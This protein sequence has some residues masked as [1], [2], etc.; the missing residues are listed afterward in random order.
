MNSLSRITVLLGVLALGPPLAAQE[1]TKVPLRETVLFPF[2]D[3]GL[4]FSK[5]LI[6]TLNPGHKSDHSPSLGIDPKHPGTPVM[7]IGKKGDP[8]YPRAYFCGTILLVEGEYRM[9]YSGFDGHKRQVCYA[10]SKDGAHWEKPKLGLV[11]YNGGKDNNLVCIDGQEAMK[12]MIN[13][14]LHDPEDPDPERRFKMVREINPELKP[15]AISADGLSWKSVAGGR[16]I[17]HGGNM[18]PSGLIKF[19]GAYYIYG[20]GG[21]VPHPIQIRGYMRAQKRMMVTLMSYDFENWTAAGHVS[22]RRDDLPPRGIPDFEF[23]RGEQVH[24]GASVWNRGN[25]LLG[26]YGQYHNPTND[27]RTSS[28][29]IGLVVSSDGIHFKEPLPDFKIIPGFEEDDRAEPRITQ[30]QAFHN[31]GD[32]TFVYY[33]I[34]TEND[35]NSPTG[36]RVATWPRDRLGYFAPVPSAEEAHCISSPISNVADESRVCLN[37]TGLSDAGAMTVEILDE[38]FRPLPGYAAADFVPITAKSGIHMPVAWRGGATLGQVKQPIRIR[39]NWSG[40]NQENVRLFAIYLD[41]PSA[42]SK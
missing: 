35:R 40:E 37:V 34:W 8:D 1:K 15:A 16:D 3:H 33:G 13:L 22:F 17:I 10:T 19:N 12:G 38:Q 21:P 39:V 41:Q 14:V 5:G 4:P 25:V 24:L 23:H 27:R 20:H 7:P 2:D 42:P 29:D 31:I 9:W 6:L 28:C 30:G 11:E 18:E 26:F 36:V 32:R